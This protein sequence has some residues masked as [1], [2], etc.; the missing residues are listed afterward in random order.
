MQT[1]NHLLILLQLEQGHAQGALIC[2]DVRG[3][4][5]ELLK[6]EDGATG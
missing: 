2:T 3:E 6:R 4:H 5:T 1:N